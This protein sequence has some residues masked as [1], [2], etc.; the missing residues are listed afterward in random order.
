MFIHTPFALYC[1]REKTCDAVCYDC[2]CKAKTVFLFVTYAIIVMQCYDYFDHSVIENTVRGL[3]MTN[4]VAA[5]ILY[6]TQ[7]ETNMTGTESTNS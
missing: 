2:Y 3:T 1:H 6:A 4:H 7:D 5:Y